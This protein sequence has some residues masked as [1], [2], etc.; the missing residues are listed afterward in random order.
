MTFLN[1]NLARKVGV[2]KHCLTG[3]FRIL[4]VHVVKG[5]KRTMI[6]ARV[7]FCSR[8]RQSSLASRPR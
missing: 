6:F 4:P 5:S 1:N 2:F 7:L 8:Y 3:R